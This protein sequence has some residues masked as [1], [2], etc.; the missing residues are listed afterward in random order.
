MYTSENI[1]SPDNN[2]RPAPLTVEEQHD[3]WKRLK[4]YHTT[5]DG[6]L[7]IQSANH[8][9]VNKNYFHN[10]NNVAMAISQ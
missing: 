8:T 4:T 2:K 9:P 3:M 5:S 10:F 6:T 7:T 1:P